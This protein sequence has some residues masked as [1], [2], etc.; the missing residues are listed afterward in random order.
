MRDKRSVSLKS[1]AERAFREGPSAA[2]HSLTVD[3]GTE[4]AKHDVLS[5]RLDLS[6]YFA[7]PYS[8]WQPGTNE[9]TNG[10]L[11][12]FLPKTADPIPC[13]SEC[14]CIPCA[15]A[16]TIDPV[17]DSAI[18]RQPQPFI[19]SAVTL[20]ML[21]HHFFDMRVLAVVKRYSRKNKK[22]G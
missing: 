16:S 12:Q 20:D 15:T 6:I 17:K 3:N 18:S 19:N 22:E 1:A 14:P 10:L 9:N 11:R 21:F 13:A 5:C 8:S 7:D 4:F 2:R